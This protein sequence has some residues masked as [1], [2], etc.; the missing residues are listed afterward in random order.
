MKDGRVKPMHA[1]NMMS[2]IVQI[3][4][5]LESRNSRGMR[6]FKKSSFSLIK[7]HSYKFDY[8]NVSLDKSNTDYKKSKGS[9]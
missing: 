5:F 3:L 1:E 8:K 6:S 2:H 7:I 4:T 9:H